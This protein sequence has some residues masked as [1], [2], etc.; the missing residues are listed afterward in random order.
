MHDR[1]RSDVPLLHTECVTHSAGPALYAWCR[2]CWA[3]VADLAVRCWTSA[4]GCRRART[5]RPAHLKR[6]QPGA[7]ATAPASALPPLQCPLTDDMHRVLVTVCLVSADVGVAR[8][9]VLQM[10]P[11]KNP[12]NVN[13]STRGQPIF[14]CLRKDVRGRLWRWQ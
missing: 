1:P 5:R 4:C 13:Y 10:S 8:Y 11:L 14:L 6:S 7:C 12:A 2:Y 3:L 9:H